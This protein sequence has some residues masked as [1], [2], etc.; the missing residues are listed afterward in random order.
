MGKHTKSLL[1]SYLFSHNCTEPIKF[2][3]FDLLFLL[4]V[5]NKVEH[6]EWS[7]GMIIDYIHKQVL[8]RAENPSTPVMR[9]W[10]NSSEKSNEEKSKRERRQEKRKRERERER[11]REGGEDEGPRKNR[12]FCK[13]ILSQVSQQ[14][15]IFYH[16]DEVWKH[17]GGEKNKTFVKFNTSI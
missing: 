2:L 4:H 13:S 1:Y 8:V 9:Y 15:E 14:S 10:K 17:K 3:H 7:R 16:H 5:Y 11:V 12:L 6:E